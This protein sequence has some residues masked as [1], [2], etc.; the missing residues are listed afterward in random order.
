MY[1]AL[2]FSGLF[3]SIGVM[4]LAITAFM[5]GWPFSGLPAVIAMCGAA[6]ISLVAIVALSVG[7]P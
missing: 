7:A 6:Y 4:V 5:L 1:L 2:L 3:V